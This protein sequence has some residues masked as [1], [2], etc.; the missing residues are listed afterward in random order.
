MLLTVLFT[1][2]SFSVLVQSNDD[3]LDELKQQ[4]L[5]MIM[6]C[7]ADT[8]LTETDIEQ[9]KNKQMPDKESIKCL[10][11]CAYTKAGIMSEDGFLS[12][13]G[14][15][16]LAQTYLEN[17]PERL[18]KAEQLTEACKFVNDENID[19]NIACER[20]ALIFKCTVDRAEEAMTDEEAKADFAKAIM[21]CAKDASVDMSDIMSLASLIVPTD[22]KVKC[23]LA[24]AYRKKGSLNAQGMYDIDGAY[25][26]AETMMKGDEVR[27]KKGKELADVCAAVNDEK[28]SD[29]EKGCD[30]AALM[31][32]CG[33]KNA[34]KY[35]FKL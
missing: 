33:V 26:L 3:K 27:I 8:P 28:V 34:A 17:D 16:K 29:G 4:Y 21:A 7:S 19:G 23:V 9:L 30:R 22:H 6:D 25:A 10:F 24:C 1:V 13:E 15:N 2:V 12:V 35:G 5:Q 20:A 18:K 31:F 32:K 11:A 14:T